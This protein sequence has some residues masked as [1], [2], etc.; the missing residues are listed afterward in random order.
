M[1]FTTLSCLSLNN[2]NLFNIFDQFVLKKIFFLIIWIN[3]KN[4]KKKRK[5]FYSQKVWFSIFLSNPAFSFP[6][7]FLLCVVVMYV[8]WLQVL[9]VLNVYIT[10]QRES[11]CPNF[12]LSIS[13][14]LSFMLAPVGIFFCLVAGLLFL[15]IGR[16]VRVHHN[17]RVSSLLPD[18]FFFFTFTVFLPQTI[19]Q[20]V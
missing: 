2:G 3:L 19:P 8:L 16:T 11:L 6:G 5:Q 12:Q 1:D 7:L 10:R 4:L 13:Y 20:H 14:G 18:F 15:L 9:D 17:W